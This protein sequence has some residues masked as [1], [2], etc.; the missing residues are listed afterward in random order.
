M[1]G[2]VDD[3]E[4]LYDEE[5][6]AR[7]DQEAE[8]ARAVA[9]AETRQALRAQDRDRSKRA[10]RRRMADSLRGWRRCGLKICR[11]ARSCRTAT[12]QCVGVRHNAWPV[13]EE[14]AAIEAYYEALQRHWQAVA[15][16]G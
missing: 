4:V 3:V 2:D 1:A 16:Q 9:E 7:R 10:V 13:A 12:T 8:T 14:A 6:L 11:R 5:F 15:A